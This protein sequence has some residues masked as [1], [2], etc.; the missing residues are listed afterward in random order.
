[1]A[2][3]HWIM[4]TSPDL[5]QLCGVWWCVPHLNSINYAA[6]TQFGR[7]FG[8]WMRV[9]LHALI[10]RINTYLFK[11]LL[12]LYKLVANPYYARELTCLCD[13]LKNNYIKSKIDNEIIPFNEF[14]LFQFNFC[15]DLIKKSLFECAISCENLPIGFRY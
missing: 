12:Q 6:F 14:L 15:Y 3:I 10:F 7:E 5:T 4:R 2:K 1:M 13:R 11:K 8:H 9:S